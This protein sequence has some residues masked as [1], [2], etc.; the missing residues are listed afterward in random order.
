[1]QAQNVSISEEK[2]LNLVVN[3]KVEKKFYL[4]DN[5][6]IYD[7]NIIVYKI[8]NDNE[9][10]V[11]STFLKM[12]VKANLDEEFLS[13]LRISYI[14]NLIT[15]QLNYFIDPHKSLEDLFRLLHDK[16]KLDFTLDDL[17]KNLVL[18]TTLEKKRK[19]DTDT[20]NSFLYLLTGECIR[21]I[22]KGSWEVE[23]DEV[24]FYHYPAIISGKNVYRL[25]EVI[26]KYKEGDADLKTLINIYVSFQGN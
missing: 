23:L 26:N 18:L 3:D 19:I 22:T 25:S 17:K 14:P 7:S 20:Y 8:F 9:Y 11:Y 10:I 1:M 6:G 16:L 5:Q 15:K 24:F 12:G 2:I 13:F 4:E 21:D